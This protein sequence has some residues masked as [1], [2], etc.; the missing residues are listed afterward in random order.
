VK[1]NAF[2]STPVILHKVWADPDDPPYITVDPGTRLFV[3][4]SPILHQW[5]AS[6]SHIDYRYDAILGTSNFVLDSA[7]LPTEAIPEKAE[8][9][10]LN[11][12][13]FIE[14]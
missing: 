6:I 3:C 12:L 11:R 13:K 10:Y 4:W 8:T 5:I 14:K 1:Y 9:Y 7:L 2:A